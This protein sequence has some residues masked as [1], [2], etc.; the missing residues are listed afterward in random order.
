MDLGGDVVPVIESRS[1]RPR[2]PAAAGARCRIKVSP[3][4]IPEKARTLEDQQKQIVNQQTRSGKIHEGK[5]LE[6]QDPF[7]IQNFKDARKELL[8]TQEKEDEEKC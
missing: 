4:I 1:R 8:D 5:I 6:E 3:F 7:M 2:R